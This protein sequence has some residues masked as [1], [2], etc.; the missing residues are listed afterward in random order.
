MAMS[1]W[2]R[3]RRQ[4]LWEMSKICFVCQKVI[5]NFQESSIEHIIPKSLGGTYK[6]RNLAL[7]HVMC[8]QL[9]GSTIC[10]IVWEL[11]LSK[12]GRRYLPDIH[13]LEDAWLEKLS[14]C[15]GEID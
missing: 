6:L 7:S 14:Q 5:R 10:R 9:R 12:E 11:K 15:Y 2:R 3:K 1:V 8:N 13:S 4:K